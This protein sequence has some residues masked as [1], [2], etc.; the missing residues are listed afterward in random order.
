MSWRVSRK[1][2]RRAWR[3]VWGGFS[4]GAP[5]SCELVR[6]RAVHSIFEE[7]EKALMPGPGG[8]VRCR[9][10]AE[11]LRRSRKDRPGGGGACASRGVLEAESRL[12]LST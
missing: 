8:P 2:V 3:E 9:A 10:E 6:R 12:E 1:A 11:L 7:E 4:V 5:S